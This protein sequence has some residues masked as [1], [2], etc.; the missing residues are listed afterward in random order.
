MNS[1]EELDES[2]SILFNA[3][4][5]SSNRKNDYLKL[6]SMKLQSPLPFKKNADSISQGT[7]LDSQYDLNKHQVVNPSD[8]PKALFQQK[9]G[10]SEMIAA[11]G[12]SR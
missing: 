2:P 3:G 1:D 5:A 4:I 12:S 8:V 10:Q 11:K 7:A 9:Q 6:Q